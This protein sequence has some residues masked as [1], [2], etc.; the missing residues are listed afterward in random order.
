MLIERYDLKDGLM[1]KTGSNLSGD[2][3]TLEL[4]ENCIDYIKRNYE[5]NSNGLKTDNAN[6]IEIDGVTYVSYSDYEIIEFISLNSDLSKSLEIKIK[7]EKEIYEPE[8]GKVLVCVG[9]G[10]YEYKNCRCS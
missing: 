5:S 2:Y 6:K 3:V 9:H 1:I 4:F 8:P 7:R 10:A